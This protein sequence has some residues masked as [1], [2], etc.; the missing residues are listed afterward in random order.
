MGFCYEYNGDDWV[1]EV[2]NTK[3]ACEM[4]SGGKFID[5]QCPKQ[6]VVGVCDFDI[7]EESGKVIRYYYN[8]PNFDQKTA[9]LSC[10]GKFSLP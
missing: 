1:S 8:Q 5:G 3:N 10:P 9:R 7:E 6:G 4:V 2:E